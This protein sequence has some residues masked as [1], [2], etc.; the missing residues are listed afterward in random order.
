VIDEAIV[1][2]ATAGP[3]DISLARREPDGTIRRAEYANINWIDRLT[4]SVNVVVSLT[5]E[6]DLPLLNHHMNYNLARMWTPDHV[7][8]LTWLM[9]GYFTAMRKY[10]GS[11]LMDTHFEVGAQQLHVISGSLGV[12]P[13]NY[14]PDKSSTNKLNWTIRLWERA[15][16]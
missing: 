5:P 3:Q 2:L 10:H 7:V 15:N 8:N 11:N 9:V 6:I 13:R 12:D 14:E 4:N 1:F 16:N